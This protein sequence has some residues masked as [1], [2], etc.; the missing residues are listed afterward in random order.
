MWETSGTYQS[1][2]ERGKPG[3]VLVLPMGG[4]VCMFRV[5]ATRGDK[6]QQAPRRPTTW[7][8][9][10]LRKA[11]FADFACAIVGV[12]AAAQV[13]FGSNVTPAYLALSLALPVLWIITLWLVG[14]Y[15]DRF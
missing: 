13:R 3:L 10:Y 9:D 11:V 8:R 1:E 2:W 15:D 4:S 6:D 5:A 12:F 14:G 7:T